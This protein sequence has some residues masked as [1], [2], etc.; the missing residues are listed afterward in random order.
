MIR[1][2]VSAFGATL[3]DCISR[4]NNIQ[5]FNEIHAQLITSGGILD[6]FVRT[7]F[8]NI[9]VSWGNLT[10]AYSIISQ[11]RR[12]PSSFAV[13]A[14]ITGYSCSNKRASILVYKDM[15]RIGFMPDKYTF[16]AVLKSCAKSLGV[17]EGK[18]VHAIACKMGFLFDIY[19]QNSLVHFYSICSEC[20]IAGELFEEMAVR[21][22]VSWTG[23]IS[24]Y[25]RGGHFHKAIE[26]FLVMDVEP[27]M[28]TFVSV[29]VACGR[30]RLLGMGKGTHGLILKHGA[31]KDLIVGNALLDMYMKCE[32]LDEARQVFDELLIRDIVSW[33]SM[34]CG[35]V[36][37]KQPE[38]ALEVFH[39]MQISAIEPD[40]VTLA[41]VLSACATLGTLSSGRWV[42]EY[43]DH[44][45]IEWDPHIGTAM[46]DMYSKCGCIDRALNTFHFLP[47]KNVFTWNA[48]IGGL[49][50]HGYG[51]EAIYYFSKMVEIGESP[52]EVTFLSV[53]SACVHAGL[54]DGGRLY[55]N[56]MTRNY[57]LVPRIEHYGCMVDLLGRAGLL[58]DAL[59]LIRSMPM[60]ADVLMW[61]AMLSACKA[62]GNVD[63]SQQILSS[64]LELE[65]RDSGIYVLLSNIYAA[66]DRWE[67]VTRLRR[68]MKKSG[69]RKAPGSSAIEI[70]GKTHEFIVGDRYKHP[71][72]EKVNLVLA[73]LMRVLNP[74]GYTSLGLEVNTDYLCQVG[75]GLPGHEAT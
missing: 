54:V 23:L 30:L 28:A 18:Q 67:D 64:L 36:Q 6:D 43:V 46:V 25:V 61:G 10:H 11:I 41:S 69:I 44:K 48:L 72:Q 42:H 74:E 60:E 1:R 12:P 26:L 37:C 47:H 15:M 73:M 9:L 14:L 70:N 21:D 65:S 33:T 13:N 50:M 31:D 7:K 32:S 4:S 24:G 3:L 8:I 52:N 71:E 17:A 34:I 39:L 68:L 56:Q 29:I 16:P 75:L 63:L 59:E 45:G 58:G 20:D 19:V 35:L 51:K 27:N 5:S 22:V 55:F 57:N 40:K 66:N 38:D 49:A 62:H 2:V 53:L